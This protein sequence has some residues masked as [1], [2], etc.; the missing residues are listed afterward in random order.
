MNDLI[1]LQDQTFNLVDVAGGTNRLKN[2]VVTVFLVY[3]LDAD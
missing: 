1:A 3:D 2:L